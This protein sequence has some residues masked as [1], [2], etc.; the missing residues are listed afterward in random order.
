MMPIPVPDVPGALGADVPADAEGLP[1]RSALSPRQRV[2]VD[3]SAIGDLALR[4]AAASVLSTTVAPAVV[5]N[6]MRHPGGERSNLGFYAELA[7]EQDPAK[8]F[9]APTELPRR[10]VT[11]GQPA[12]G[13][14]RERDGR[15]H[16]VPQQLHRDQPRDAKAVER[17]YLQ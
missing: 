1:P 16:R 10:P 11:A 9:P 6:A 5:A 17:I 14:A 7:A 2:V 13:V 12:G 4:T 3:V 15:Q 8:S